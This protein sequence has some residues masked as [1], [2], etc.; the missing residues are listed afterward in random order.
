[1][2]SWVSCYLFCQ[3]PIK[4]MGASFHSPQVGTCL[5]TG[6]ALLVT[7]VLTKPSSVLMNTSHH[8]TAGW[9]TCPLENLGV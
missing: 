9:Y 3:H 8:R 4:T 7:G 1:M 5:T 2:P 6:R